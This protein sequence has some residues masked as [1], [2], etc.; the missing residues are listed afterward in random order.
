MALPKSGKQALSSLLLEVFSFEELRIFVSTLDS[1]VEPQL[2]ISQPLKFF[3]HD[4]IEALERRGEIDAEFFALLSNVRPKRTEEIQQVAVLLEISITSEAV[5]NVNRQE[6]PKFFKIINQERAISIMGYIIWTAILM[7]LILPNQS[8]SSTLHSVSVR[9]LENLD[10]DSISGLRSFLARR[11]KT[12]RSYVDGLTHP[13][14]SHQQDAD[15]YEHEQAKHHILALANAVLTLSVERQRVLAQKES[16]RH[17]IALSKKIDT[18]CLN[19]SEVHSFG[20]NS[21]DLLKEF[22][23]RIKELGYGAISDFRSDEL[24]LQEQAARK[25]REESKENQDKVFYDFTHF[26]P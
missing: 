8:Q 4:L 6:T 9:E 20:R 21:I 18:L 10:R 23:V 16:K 22:S 12:F 19:D 13:T 5:R 17:I 24:D 11:E 2:N 25:N 3:I 14:N 15:G 26:W 1:D 7:G